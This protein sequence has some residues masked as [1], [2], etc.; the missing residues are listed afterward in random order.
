MNAIVIEHVPLAELPQAWREKLGTGMPLTPDA[1]VTVR[2][3]EEPANASGAERADGYVTDD[4]AFGIW[5]D[6]Q[7]VADVEAYLRRV[8]SPR[9]S[10]DG[11]HKEQP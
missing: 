4:P 7:D 10:S 9:F 5:R 6:R 8:R 3:E 2:I 11:S 1:K